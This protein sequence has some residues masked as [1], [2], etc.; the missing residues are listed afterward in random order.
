ME[1]QLAARTGAAELSRTLVLTVWRKMHQFW[2][3]NYLPSQY[4]YD[5][6]VNLNLILRYMFELQ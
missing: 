3:V 4:T 6:Y 2:K 5:A 1:E